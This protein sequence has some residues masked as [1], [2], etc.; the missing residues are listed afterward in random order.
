[1]SENITQDAR[2]KLLLIFAGYKEPMHSFLSVNPGLKSRI[3][4]VI[5]FDDYSTG[6]LVQIAHQIS[7]RRGLSLDEGAVAK[8]R[9]FMDKMRSSEGFGNARD[10]ENLMDKAQRNLTARLSKLGNLATEKEMT[11]IIEA[12]IPD[13]PSGDSSGEKKTIGFRT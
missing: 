10:V 13:I 9:A 1:M 8:I 2:D 6:E 7:G 3:P 4:S 11:L 12:D 5:E